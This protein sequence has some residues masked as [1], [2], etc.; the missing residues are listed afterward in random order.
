MYVHGPS[1]IEGNK[2]IC[3]ILARVKFWPFQL[4]KNL[5]QAQ[6]AIE[7]LKREL[8]PQLFAQPSS[9]DGAGDTEVENNLE[10][11]REDSEFDEVSFQ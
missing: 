2:Y 7:K 6:E 1:K 8:Y 4:F 3:F 11:I 10:A 5:A 9:H